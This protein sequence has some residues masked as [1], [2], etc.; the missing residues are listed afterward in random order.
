[1]IGRTEGNLNR[2]FLIVIGALMTALPIRGGEQPLP[3][4]PCTQAAVDCAPFPDRMSAYVWRNWFVVPHARLAAAVGASEAELEGVAV[5]MGLP[6]KV[7]VLP[8]WRRRGYITVVRR[9]WHLLD[10][11]QLLQVVD[12]TREELAFSLMED[13]FLFVKLGNL[14]PKCG[15]LKWNVGEVEKG[16]SARRKIAEALKKE[17]VDPSAAEEPRFAFIKELSASSPQAQPSTAA[18]SSPFDFRLIF[19]YFADYADPLWDPEVGSYPEGLLQKLAAQGVNAVWLHTVLRTLAKDPKYPEFGEGSERRIANLQTLVKRCDRYG[20]KVFLYMN[21]PRGMPESFFAGKPEREAFR[22]CGNRNWPLFAM[23]TSVPEVRRWVRDSIAS[24]FKQVPGL[25]GIFTITMSENLTN[26]ASR[27]DKAKCPRCRNRSSSEIVAEINA[28]MIEGMRAGNPDAVALLYDW[29]WDRTDDGKAGVLARLPKR[30]VR[31]LSVSERGMPV[32]RGGKDV[33]VSDYAISV[34]GPGEAARQTWRLARAN[35]IPTTAKVQANCSWELAA[36]PYLPVMDLVAEHALNLVR[37]GV[38]GVMLSWSHG[39]CPA[40]NLSVF[41]DVRKTDADK[42]AVLDRIAES[43][44]GAKA[45]PL[46]RQA[47]TAFAEGYRHFPFSCAVVYH[48]PQE[49]GPANPLYRERTGYKA[50]MVGIPYDDV[51]G[52]CS[53]Y[54]PDVWANQMARV[55]DGFDRGC[56]LFG[57]AL[58]LMPAAT[59][60]AA[61]KELRMFRAEA[62]H[63]RSCVDQVALYQCREAGD[64]AGLRRQVAKELASA[65]E[66]LD[67][68]RRDSRFGYES[69]NQYFY[70]PQDLREKIVACRLF[71]D[72]SEE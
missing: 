68:A 54:P 43:L 4:E 28:A 46:V 16:G 40:P 1:M 37:E 66:L 64:S 63:F 59:R 57:K 15:E 44:Y 24:V 48:G 47:W 50:T 11:P 17:G 21:E 53:Q 39:C 25:G 61:E 60:L 42:S 18:S 33:V 19:S 41:R 6:A 22:G 56:E 36:F 55:R 9:N 10:Y 72:R 69:S 26:C 5:E 52:W 35:G 62:L 31:I 30:N 23:C 27:G 20:I 67:L 38:D 8:E 49:M 70:I 65:K 34:V 3:G 71:L 14:K 2:L 58:D 32:N 51:K 7:D 45:R 29:A 12:M 13:D